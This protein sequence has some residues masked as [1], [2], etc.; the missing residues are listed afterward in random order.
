MDISDKAKPAH[1]RKTK[2]PH[3]ARHDLF[4]VFDVIFGSE[5]E[6]IFA[7]DGITGQIASQPRHQYVN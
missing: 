1:E 4:E 2:K 5:L 3:A 6:D 7:N